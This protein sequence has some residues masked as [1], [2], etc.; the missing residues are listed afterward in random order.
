MEEAERRTESKRHTTYE[1]LRTSESP[2]R[3]ILRVTS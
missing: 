2:S 1:V 3:H